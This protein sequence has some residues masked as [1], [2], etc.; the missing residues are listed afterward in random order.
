MIIKGKKGI[1]WCCFS[2]ELFSWMVDFWICGGN[3][4]RVSGS[5]GG[6]NGNDSDC[7][8]DGGGGVGSSSDGGDGSGSGYGW[9]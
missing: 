9:L 2:K 7:V 4:G 1:S 6:S 5:G 8:G 3:G